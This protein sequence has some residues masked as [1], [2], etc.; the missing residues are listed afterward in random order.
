LHVQVTKSDGRPYAR[1]IAMASLYCFA[2][3]R[4]LPTCVD[5]RI[6]RFPQATASAAG[7]ALTVS[8]SV[9]YEDARIFFWPSFDVTYLRRWVL[10]F[11][12]S[13]HSFS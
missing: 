12:A 1:T 6:T 3:Y 9:P 13:P 8:R 7:V 5:G 2:M 11:A 10:I 4:G